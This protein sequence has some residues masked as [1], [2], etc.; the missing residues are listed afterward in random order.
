MKQTIWIARHGIRQDFVDSNWGKTAQW[1]DE[2]G[3]SPEGII[4]AKDLAERLK[5]ENIAHIFS[6]PFLR[7]LETV[8]YTAQALNLKIKVEAG[9]SEWL[10]EAW[11]A[12]GP[13]LIPFEQKANLFPE[14]DTSY[15]SLVTPVFPETQAQMKERVGQTVRLITEK[16]SGDILLVGHG[17]SVQASAQALV[18]EDKDINSALC[19][20][21]KI[22]REDQGWVLEL[23]GD[24]SHLSIKNISTRGN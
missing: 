21:M 4:Q 18:G 10:K 1:P 20:L 3:L 14:I 6:S 7:A 9:L 11:F 2:P 23:N 13:V 17:A 5:Q 22:V 12:P 15:H 8:K 19:C 24:L 16:T